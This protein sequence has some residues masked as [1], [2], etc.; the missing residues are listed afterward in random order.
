ME[1][2]SII[3]IFLVFLCMVFGYELGPENDVILAVWLG[4]LVAPLIG[5]LTTMLAILMI[6]EIGQPTGRTKEFTVKT[7]VILCIMSPV[8]L[9][10]TFL[11]WRT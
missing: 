5:W 3:S 4:A 10:L 6:M 1:Y 8:F 9:T 2:A 7:C 11:L